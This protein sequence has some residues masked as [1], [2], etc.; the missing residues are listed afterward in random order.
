LKEEIQFLSWLPCEL[1]FFVP[2]NNPKS[3]GQAPNYSQLNIVAKLI[4]NPRDRF[5]FFELCWL[6]KN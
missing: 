1:L 4:W 3:F 5:E 6:V 2:S